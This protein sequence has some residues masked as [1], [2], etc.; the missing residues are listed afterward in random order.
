MLLPNP[1]SFDI[2]ANS[3]KVASGYPSADVSTAKCTGRTV[4]QQRNVYALLAPNKEQHN[5][6][7]GISYVQG[8]FSGLTWPQVLA[9]VV[10]RFTLE[11][12]ST[13]MP[14]MCAR[15]DRCFA[16]CLDG[17]NRS[18]CRAVL[19]RSMGEH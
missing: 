14:P 11:V 15:H 5:L 17:K 4:K 12:S 1:R 19:G 6:I 13:S 16:N 10:D 2:V 18:K 3:N 7:F 8:S 9:R